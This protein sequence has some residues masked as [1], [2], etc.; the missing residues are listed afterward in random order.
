MFCLFYNYPNIEH[1]VQSLTK[2]VLEYPEWCSHPR[3]APDR[4]HTFIPHEEMELMQLST[5]VVCVLDDATSL[6]SIDIKAVSADG[7]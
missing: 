5:P 6:P 3:I 1:M 7:D 2:K 4:A